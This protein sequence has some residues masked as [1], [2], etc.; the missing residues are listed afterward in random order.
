[1]QQQLWEISASCGM[2]TKANI[3]TQNTDIQN[4]IIDLNKAKSAFLYIKRGK[5][6][7]CL[8]NN[9]GSYILKNANAGDGYIF[10]KDT[11]IEQWIAT[12][13]FKEIV[14]KASDI[15]WQ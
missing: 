14:L 10:S 12:C 2:I 8:S 1:M 4:F 11:A 5:V 6:K 9:A 15:L 3:V 13:E 7:D